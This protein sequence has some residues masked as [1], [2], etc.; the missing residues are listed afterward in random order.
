[1]PHPDAESFKRL[2]DGTDTSAGATL[3]RFALTPLGAAWSTVMA[4][5]NAA[6]DRGWLAAVPAGIPVV[7]VGNLTLGGTGK[8][9]LVA[10]VV[11]RLAALQRRPAIVS[12]GYAAA[13]GQRSDEAA[14][15][16]LLLP[17]IVHVADRDRYRVSLDTASLAGTAAA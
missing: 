9:P 4:V 5:R 11:R 13:A 16:A 17:G 14:E 3:A 7:C 1:M 10:W 6:Y 2:V 12:R 8:T 15:L